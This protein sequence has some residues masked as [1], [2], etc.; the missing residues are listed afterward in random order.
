MWRHSGCRKNDFT[1]SG[2]FWMLCNAL[3]AS[4]FIFSALLTNF[5]LWKSQ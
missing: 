5:A 2:G 1:S 3:S 4:D